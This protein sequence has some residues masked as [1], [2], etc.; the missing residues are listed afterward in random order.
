VCGNNRFIWS[1][2][3]ANI[4]YDRICYRANVSSDSYITTIDY[5]G[6]AK[7]ELNLE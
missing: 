4:N 3:G 5:S 7:L 1:F 2:M 6:E